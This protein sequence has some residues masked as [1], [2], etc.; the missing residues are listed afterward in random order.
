MKKTTI[1]MG[2]ELEYRGTTVK[3]APDYKAQCIDCVL[4]GFGV[5]HCHR[6]EL[7]VSVCFV[8]NTPIKFI[9]K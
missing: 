1:T 6:D 8:G 7:G 4:M 9:K 5:K 2:M 3:V